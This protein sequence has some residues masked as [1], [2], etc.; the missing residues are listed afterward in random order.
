MERSVLLGLLCDFYGEF[1]TGEIADSL[2][3]TRQGVHDTLRRAEG[4]L[5]RCE[6]RL[7]LVGRYIRLRDLL[8]ETRTLAGEVAFSREEDGLR[9]R[10]LL[11]EMSRIWEGNNGL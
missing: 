2:G 10:T 11:E 8:E 3:I 4:A 6:E 9:M 5:E 7:G 1:L